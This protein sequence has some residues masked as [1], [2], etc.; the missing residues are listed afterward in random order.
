M[1][2]EDLELRL[3]REVQRIYRARSVTMI[4]WGTDG[5]P[6]LRCTTANNSDCSSFPFP[7]SMI[8][9]LEIGEQIVDESGAFIKIAD[10]RGKSYALRIGEKPEMLDVEPNKIWLRTLARYVN[11]LYEN[12]NVIKDLATELEQV[13]CL[14]IYTTAPCRNRLFGTASWK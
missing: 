6:M 13:A 5:T 11:V 1:K 10:I 9:D 2:I 4:E 12:F 7:A 14:R 8:R 3:V